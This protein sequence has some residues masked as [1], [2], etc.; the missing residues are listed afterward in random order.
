MAPLRWYSAEAEHRQPLDQFICTDPP[1][2]LYEKHR[3]PHHPRVWE[4]EVQSH[5]RGLRVP[6]AAGDLLGLGFDDAGLAAAI[7]CGFD[8]TGSQ[9]MIWAV[10]CALRCRRNGYGVQAVR[11]A[12]ST[13]AATKRAL[14]GDF[15]MITHIDPRNDASRGLFRSQGFVYLNLNEGYEVWVRDVDAAPGT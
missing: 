11:L 1:K 10:A 9:I 14:G 7:H 3:G 13:A 8:D 15:G 12:I 2:R 4:L 6:V 5:L